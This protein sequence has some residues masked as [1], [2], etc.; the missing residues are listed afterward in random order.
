MRL[1]LLAYANLSRKNGGEAVKESLAAIAPQY[2]IRKVFHLVNR[3]WGSIPS[4]PGLV[5][6][7]RGCR[8]PSR[9]SVLNLT[10]ADKRSTASRFGSFS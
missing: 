10:G 4:Q 2:A 6:A 9:R 5:H 8:Q 3:P 1:A 7:H